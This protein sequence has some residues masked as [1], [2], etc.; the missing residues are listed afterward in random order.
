MLR[1][2]RSGLL[3]TR[4]SWI[5]T[6]AAEQLGFYGQYVLDLL[7]LAEHVSDGRAQWLHPVTLFTRL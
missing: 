7:I 6:L 1:M 4:P 3:E 2:A 5:D